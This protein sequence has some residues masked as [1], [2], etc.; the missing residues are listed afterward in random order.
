MIIYFAPMEGVTNFIFRGVYS[1]LYK[2]IEKY[3]TPFIAANEKGLLGPR[4]KREILPENNEGIFLVPQILTSNSLSFIKTAKNLKKYGYNEVNLNLGCPSGTVVSKNKGSG[5]LLNPLFLRNFLDEIFKEDNLEISIKTRI[6]F[7]SGKEME[8]LLKIFNDYPIKELIVHPRVREDFYKNTPNL[9]VFQEIVQN[10][11]NSLCYNGDL[12]N[13]DQIKIFNESFPE[14]NKIMIG[15]GLIANPG[16]IREYNTGKK[17]EKIEYRVFHDELFSSYSNYLSGDRNLMF[18]MKE[19]WKFWGS[20]FP[21]N[22]KQ[23]KK[24]QK[25]QNIFSYKNAVEKFFE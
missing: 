3:Y 13:V 12:F 1:K 7:S 23:V 21:E 14:V 11:K 10:S 4:F 25:S 5:M 22:R 18:K 19:Y 17:I 15:R 6:G 8:E 9:S 16:L 20:N 24:I 2:G